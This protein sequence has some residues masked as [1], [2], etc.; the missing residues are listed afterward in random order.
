MGEGQTKQPEVNKEI[1]IQTNK[2]IT[3]ETNHTILK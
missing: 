2:E 1:T 3:I